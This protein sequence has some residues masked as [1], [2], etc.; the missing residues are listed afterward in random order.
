LKSHVI[1]DENVAIFASGPPDRKAI[2]CA[3][4]ILEITRGREKLILFPDLCKR[5]SGK[6]SKSKLLNFPA[7]LNRL[8]RDPT[9][10]EWIQE[11]PDFNLPHENQIT[12]DMDKAIVKIAVI[13]RA[14]IITCDEKLID[15]INEKNLDVEVENPCVN[16]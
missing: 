11:P 8:M 1:I 13:K 12:D 2:N 15:I 7:L 5:Y 14:K 3:S 16:T 4:K 9:K 6:A 10:V